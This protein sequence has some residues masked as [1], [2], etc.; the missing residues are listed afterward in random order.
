MDRRSRGFKL[1]SLTKHPANALKDIT[2]DSSG[3]FS[4]SV[5]LNKTIK[6]FKEKDQD[7]HT[8]TKSAENEKCFA[9]ENEELQS[10]LT[11]LQK[12]IH[13]TQNILDI[14]ENNNLSSSF[15]NN[16]IISGIEQTDIITNYDSFIFFDE[17]KMFNANTTNDIAAQTETTLDFNKN[18]RE[19][20][21]R[22]EDNDEEEEVDNENNDPTYQIDDDGEQHSDEENNDS[23]EEVTQ[24]RKK[25]RFFNPAEWKY[26]TNKINREKGVKYM[27][28]KNNKFDRKKTKRVMKTRYLCSNKPLK[29]GKE[30][31]I[32]CNK[33]THE[34]RKLIFAKCW[35][36]SWSEK[37]IYI[38]AKVLKNKTERSGHRNDPEVSQRTTSYKYFLKK[39]SEEIRV[40]KKEKREK[41]KTVKKIECKQKQLEK[42]ARKT[43]FSFFSEENCKF[44]TNYSTDDEN[45]DENE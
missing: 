14:G 22:N 2:I 7:S 13:M 32:Q 39:K 19:G 43:T 29:T 1:L 28:R 30:I 6:L 35:S 10:A 5:E 41:G 38:F 44:L 45:F 4:D 18:Q 8:D 37:K 24:K 27:G 26:N 16:A 36:L 31:A 11:E 20:N 42:L 23:S 15:L 9:E 3:T 40:Y 33:L 25:K 17:I 34:E 21:I 12:E